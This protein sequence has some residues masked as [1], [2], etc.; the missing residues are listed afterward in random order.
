MQTKNV[1]LLLVGALLV[2]A[3]SLPVEPTPIAPMIT[4]EVT[5]ELTPEVPP[6]PVS[7]AA[8][9]RGQNALIDGVALIG[10]PATGVHL[11]IQGH[12][13]DGC[14]QLDTVTQRVE[15]GRILLDVYTVRPLDA[16]CTQALVPFTHTVPL[17]VTGLAPGEYIVDV[18]GVTT[19]LALSNEST[20]PAPKPTETPTPLPP[21][22]TPISAEPQ[23]EVVATGLAVPWALA[24]GPHG[25]IYVTERAGRLRVIE[26]GVLRPEP[27]G[28]VSAQAIGEGGLM[29]LA[30]DP[31][32]AQNGWLYLMYTY[33]EGG[34]ILNRIS[35]FTLTDTGLAEEF[36]LLEGIPGARYHN[37]GRLALGPD[38][39][40][41][42]ATG[43]AQAPALAQDLGSLA[44]KILRLNLDGTIPEDN[45]FPGSPVYSLG[46]RNPQGLAFQPG[47]NVLYA[48]EHGPTGEFGLCCRD[49]LNRIV[50]GATMAG[51]TSRA[52]TG[53]MRPR[54]RPST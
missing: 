34:Q 37:G 27:V 32:F 45:P 20:A 4:P 9:A 40:L 43:D 54:P 35:R 38:G 47:T 53:W 12:F 25:E 22:L 17:D 2:A 6:K 39:K 49:E 33:A 8:I 48:V 5:R 23:V 42:A 16:L 44:G 26:G 14:T 10:E 36:A 11:E 31:E 21:A 18:Q 29:G 30:L 46:H 50:P 7:D 3:C 19:T 28:L 41:Y 15:E 13:R 51:R 1:L 24:F 52:R